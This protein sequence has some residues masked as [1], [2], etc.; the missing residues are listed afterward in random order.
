M[1]IVYVR[2]V[3]LLNSSNTSG[4]SERCIHLQYS[5]HYLAYC[6][7]SCGPVHFTLIISRTQHTVCSVANMEI[8]GEIKLAESFDARKFK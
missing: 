1:C 2:T 8:R 4:L 5:L 6:W 3:E 7:L